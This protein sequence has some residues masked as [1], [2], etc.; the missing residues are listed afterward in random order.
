MKGRDLQRMQS[1]P[2]GT[3]LNKSSLHSS[4]EMQAAFIFLFDVSDGVAIPFVGVS[5]DSSV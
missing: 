4:V 2:F 1:P 5:T 3:S